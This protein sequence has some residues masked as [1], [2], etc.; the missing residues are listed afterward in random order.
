[1]SRF[2]DLVS[3]PAREMGGY[4]PKAPPAQQAS[5]GPQA[6]LIRLDSNENPSG[7]SPLAIEAMRA[8][9]GNAHCY[10]DDDCGALRRKLAAHH[11]LPTEQVMVTAGST[12]APDCSPRR[13]CASHRAVKAR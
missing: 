11:G 12:A 2:F 8:T 10:P 13:H 4:T 3:K 1:M 5:T 6:R 9:L 7:P